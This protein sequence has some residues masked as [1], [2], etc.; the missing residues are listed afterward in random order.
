VGL[1]VD[2]VAFIQSFAKPDPRP[3]PGFVT[4]FCGAKVR[5]EYLGPWGEGLD[6]TLRES[7]ILRSYYGEVG[8]WYGTF[9]AV[10]AATDSFSVMELGAGYGP[11]LGVAGISAIN[12]GIK[13]L[14]LCGVEGDPVRASWMKSTWRTMA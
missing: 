6:G 3:I 1:N 13:N 9:M 10:A 7:P 4:D 8:E 14:Y 12:R 5:T 2:Q 11:W